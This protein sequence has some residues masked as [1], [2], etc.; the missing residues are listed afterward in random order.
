M[1]SLDNELDN[2]K[3]S[4]IKNKLQEDKL[5]S[6]KADDLFNKIK[7]EGIVMEENISKNTEPTKENRKKSNNKNSKWKKILATAASLVIVL[8]AANVYATTKGYDNI[9]F[10]IKYLITGNNETIEGKDNILSDK[11]I[12]I[13]YESIAIAK[14]LRITVKKLQIK[15]GKAKLFVTTEETATFDDNTVPLKFKVYNSDKEKICEQTSSRTGDKNRF[16]NDELYL[17]KFPDDDKILNLEIYTAKSK[18]LAT[19]KIDIENRTV[20]VIGEEE[21]L[22]KISEI[23]L[24]K[25]LGYVGS[26]N[27]E[28]LFS[29]NEKKIGLAIQ[30][31][32]EKN[33]NSKK[34]VII[35]DLM[36]LPKEEID[37][38]LESFLGE[39][40]T[41][42]KNGKYIMLTTKNG[43]SYY[44][45]TYGND[46]SF[47][48]E[49]IN[50]SNISYCNGLYTATYTYFFPPKDP[51]A[52]SSYEVFEQ[53]I[54]FSLND[55]SEYS[56]FKVETLGEVS[57]IK[58]ENT[59]TANI[60]E[61]NDPIVPRPDI[62]K[63]EQV[64]NSTTSEENATLPKPNQNQNTN[65]S[66][67]KVDNYAS[68]MSW[69]EYWAPGIKFQYPTDF[70]LEE[71]G[72]YY[73]GSS[74]GDL[75]TKLTG[76]AIGVDP[77]TKETLYSNL[78]IYIYE[79]RNETGDINKYKNG[80]NGLP[81]GG[82]TTKSG[83]NWYVTTSTNQGTWPY[84][85][86][87]TYV[88]PSSDGSFWVHVIEFRTDNR[89]NLKVTNII[90]WLLG[91]TKITSY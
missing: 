77:D 74:P 17:N 68:S 53:E 29:K 40:I 71:V 81:F 18:Q 4:F 27:Q 13:S 21:A 87:Y 51:E 19:L 79:P 63:E 86:K 50:V 5:I 69:T 30:M 89:N 85:E 72:G 3:D 31:W 38:M 6:K 39:T 56:K 23:E 66:D 82:F 59:S 9:F 8:G 55:N 49:C 46:I 60:V 48:G 88:S 10:M 76:K 47:D 44:K 33:P 37:N 2:K 26:L 91:S 28:T 43:S 16:V 22:Q 61:E 20:E 90:N 11:D 73:R 7:L 36:G 12:T 41:N 67:Q 64:D 34:T 78:A 45:Y 35:D 54:T 80:S 52:D 42:F 65:N 58:Q 75:S 32:A 57:I 70:T 1:K 84:V 83:L 62:P 25:F 24:K 15:D 14:D